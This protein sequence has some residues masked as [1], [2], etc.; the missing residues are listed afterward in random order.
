MSAKLKYIKAN[1]YFFVLENVYDLKDGDKI[2]DFNKCP[3]IAWAIGT[4]N[5]R[6]KKDE[7]PNCFC[8]AVTGSGINVNKPIMRPDKSIEFVDDCVFDNDELSKLWSHAL[9]YANKKEA[10]LRRI[11]AA[12]KESYA[13]PTK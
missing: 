1:P 7:S 13:N 10:N 8:Y 9:D 5:K 11:L 3:V 12:N 4:E 2:V 6:H